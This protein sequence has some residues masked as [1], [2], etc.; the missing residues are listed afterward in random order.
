MLV[1][2]NFCYFSIRNLAEPGV[3]PEK[4]PGRPKSVV[5]KIHFKQI[6][7]NQGSHA[8]YKILG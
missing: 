3:A 8:S 4:Y 1:I 2:I 6:W 5:L 7:S